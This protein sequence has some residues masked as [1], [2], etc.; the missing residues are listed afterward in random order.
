MEEGHNQLEYKQ[1][2]GDK[3]AEPEKHSH[4]NTAV[5]HIYAIK[6]FKHTEESAD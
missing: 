1:R 3:S 5:L 6:N 2:T 4:I